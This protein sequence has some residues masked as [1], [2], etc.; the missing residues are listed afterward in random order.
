MSDLVETQ[1]VDFLMRR[2]MSLLHDDNMNMLVIQR[3][4]SRLKTTNTDEVN[5]Q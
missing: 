5:V 3:Q 2:L 4:P 1:I